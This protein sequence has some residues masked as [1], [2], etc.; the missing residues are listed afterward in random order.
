M[1]VVHVV[2]LLLSVCCSCGGGVIECV[3]FICG[4]VVECVLFICGGGVV[5]CSLDFEVQQRLKL[6]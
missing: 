2:V 6:F 5:V 3:L 4:G 1:C